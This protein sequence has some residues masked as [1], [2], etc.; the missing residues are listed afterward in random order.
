MAFVT[1]ELRKA[2][3]LLSIRLIMCVEF[4]IQPDVDTV[5]IMIV[6][7]TYFVAPVWNLHKSETP[8]DLYAL[9]QITLV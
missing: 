6:T 9:D 5:E 4:S 7:Y 2:S 1:R 8:C 3:L